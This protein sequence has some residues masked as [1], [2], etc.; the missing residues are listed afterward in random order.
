MVSSQ[1]MK[2]RLEVNIMVYETNAMQKRNGVIDQVM[3]GEA[4]Y[5]VSILR[6]AVYLGYDPDPYTVMLDNRVEINI[7]HSLMTAKLGLVMIQLNHRLI[8]STNQSKSKFLGIV[9][10][11]PVLVGSF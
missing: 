4:L 2:N 11:T 7:M 6:M 9:K 1:E 8:I 10:D 3:R 5:A